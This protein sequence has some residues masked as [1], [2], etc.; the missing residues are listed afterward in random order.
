MEHV[1]LSEVSLGLSLLKSEYWRL[2]A[3]EKDLI[4]Q[5]ENTPVNRLNYGANKVS[6]AFVDI[7][8][9]NLNNP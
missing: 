6:K 3:V 9:N 2:C 4:I 7:Y 1:T 5:Q 8:S